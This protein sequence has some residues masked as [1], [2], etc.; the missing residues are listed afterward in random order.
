MAFHENKIRTAWDK[1]VLMNE[2]QHDQNINT[3]KF[4]F[5]DTC[6]GAQCADAVDGI[7]SAIDGDP[8]FMQ[9]DMLSI[10]YEGNVTGDYWVGMRD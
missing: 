4:S 9:C 2:H 3:Y 10:L 1:L 8:S 5:M 6:S 7:L